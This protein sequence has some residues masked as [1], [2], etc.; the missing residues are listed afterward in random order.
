MTKIM[1][2][3]ACALMQDTL[4][5]SGGADF[6]LVKNFVTY[7]EAAGLPLSL[8]SDTVVWKLV[9]TFFLLNEI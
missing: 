8:S 6:F 7:Q 4:F 5:Q 3:N 1:R 2:L 9:S